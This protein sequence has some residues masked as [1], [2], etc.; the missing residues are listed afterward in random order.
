M[1]VIAAISLWLLGLYDFYRQI[2]TQVSRDERKTDAIIVLTGG[3]DRVIEGILLLK[4]NYAPKIFI[5][6]VGK[7]TT[8]AELLEIQGLSEQEIKKLNLGKFSVG[9]AAV[10]TIG[11][12][13]EAENWIRQNNIRS[14]RLVTSS[15][16]MPRALL[17]FKKR[18][19]GLVIIPH[20]VIPVDFNRDNWR[21]DELSRRF[22]LR[23]YTKYL[24]AKIG[25]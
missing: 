4:Q 15:Y 5:S 25:R 18:M 2:P 6:G 14:I 16:H 3:K 21:N 1:S 22:I 17:E 10:N 20:P 12:A 8:I 23:E 11:N 9:R 13:R 24:M 19:P 7:E